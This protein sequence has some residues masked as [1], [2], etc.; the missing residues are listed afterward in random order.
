MAAV[1]LENSKLREELEKLKRQLRWSSGEG[2]SSSS[3]L[4]DSSRHGVGSA[5]YEQ[6]AGE[7]AQVRV[8]MA[9]WIGFCGN[10]CSGYKGSGLKGCRQ[11]RLTAACLALRSDR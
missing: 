10:M 9:V 6:L 7:L 4:R 2:P 5:S 8:S 11:F 3:S 1:Q